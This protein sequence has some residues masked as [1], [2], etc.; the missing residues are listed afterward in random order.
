MSEAL[1]AGIGRILTPLVA[2]SAPAGAIL[3]VRSG[4]ETLTAIGGAREL[5]S[6]SGIVADLPMTADTAFDLASITKAFTTVAL[7]RLVSD[8]SIALDDPLGR[9]V[10]AAGA[11]AGASIRSLLLHRAGLWEWWPLYMETRDPAAAHRWLDG[12]PLRYPPGEGRH[13][14]DL[15]FMHLGRVVEAVSGRQ[16]PDAI[17]EL[18]TAPLGLRE[19]RYGG[20]ASDVVA[21]GSIG[22]R[23]ERLMIETGEPYPVPYSVGDFDGWRTGVIRSSANDGNAFH[24]LAGVSGHAGLFSTVPDLLSLAA[25]LAS[26]RDDL[27]SPAVATEF[28]AQGPD[29]GQAL[30]FRRYTMELDGDP[31]V[32]VG[33]PGYTGSVI[34]FVPGRGVALVLATNR[35]HAPGVPAVTDRLWAIAR[36]AASAALG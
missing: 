4:D 34:G 12:M 2:E 19:T 23:A 16:L 3:A 17:G 11:A 18:V 6:V 8:G 36:D 29:A 22:D 27:W 15:G 28:F 21:A 20:P 30:G 25:A 14:S 1:A 32:V 13:Y 33:H 5:A 24:A 26:P 31:A 35:L 7:M 9:Y 10:P